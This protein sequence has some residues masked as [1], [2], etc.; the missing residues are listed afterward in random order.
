MENRKKI[1]GT[2]LQQWRLE[3]SKQK[4]P[5]TGAISTIT[6]LERLARPL[7]IINSETELLPAMPE[8]LKAQYSS[9]VIP[10]TPRPIRFPKFHEHT[11][12]SENPLEMIF[13]T[14][15]G[16]Y[17]EH[18]SF[19]DCIFVAGVVEKYLIENYKYLTGEDYTGHFF[20]AL[21]HKTIEMIP[22]Y[23]EGLLPDFLRVATD[24]YIARNR[25][26]A[27]CEK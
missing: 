13:A 3:S 17:Q 15:V 25:A 20:L 21:N 11:S 18:H 9:P 7:E 16:C 5:D 26:I 19:P 8:H 4:V 12:T 22:V 1:P 10:A 2:R 27:L 24:G 6:Q 14:V 23:P